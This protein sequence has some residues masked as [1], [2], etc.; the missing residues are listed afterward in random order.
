MSNV[1]IVSMPNVS[2]NV[3]LQETDIEVDMEK[4]SVDVKVEEGA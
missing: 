4:L 3:P 2:I 1:E